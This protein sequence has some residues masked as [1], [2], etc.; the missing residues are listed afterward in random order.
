MQFGI[1]AAEHDGEGRSITLL[2]EYFS[3]VAL[4]VPNSGQKLERLD[5]RVEQWDPALRAYVK[6]HLI[7]QMLWML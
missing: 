4:Y 3:V 7:R 2:Y 1:G 5:Y 6:V